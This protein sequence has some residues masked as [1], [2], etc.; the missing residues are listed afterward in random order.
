[1]PTIELERYAMINFLYLMM[2]DI[3][4]DF[5][6]PGRANMEK[7]IGTIITHIDEWKSPSKKIKKSKTQIF[8]GPWGNPTIVRNRKR[9]LQSQVLVTIVARLAK[10]VD[11]FTSKS[12]TAP[13][14]LGVGGRQLLD[15]D[16]L[17]SLKQP[18]DFLEDE[19]SNKVED[20]ISNKVEDK[21]SNKVEDK[22]S[23]KVE[24]EIS[25]KVE[26][27][28][29]N[30]VED[31]ISNKVE[32]EIS[33]KVE[34][35]ISDNVGMIN[36]VET[37]KNELIINA[38]EALEILNDGERS[39]EKAIETILEPTTLNFELKKKVQI[40]QEETLNEIK[41]QIN[42]TE[43]F[44]TVLEGL[45]L[46]KMAEYLN[47]LD[48]NKVGNLC[49]VVIF[50]ELLKQ[51]E[52]I[53]DYFFKNILYLLGYINGTEPKDIIHAFNILLTVDNNDFIYTAKIVYE[54]FVSSTE[55]N[56]KNILTSNI[57]Y[58]TV[59]ITFYLKYYHKDKYKDLI[60]TLNDPNINANFASILNFK[61]DADADADADADDEHNEHADL[62]KFLKEIAE[63]FNDCDT[64]NRSETIFD[65]GEKSARKY[66]RRSTRRPYVGG[67]NIKTKTKNKTKTK[68]KTKT[69][70]KTKNKTKRSTSKNKSLKNVTNR[71]V[72]LTGL[73]FL[74][75][76]KNAFGE[77]Y[78][79]VL[80]NQ[81]N[82]SEE[83][84]KSL[85]E[86]H[87]ENVL[88]MNTYV[89][90]RH[91]KE[92][93]DEK[94]LQLYT[95]ALSNFNT[96]IWKSTEGVSKESFNNNNLQKWL[97]PPLPSISSPTGPNICG[98]TGSNEQ[99][100]LI[101]NA[102][103]LGSKNPKE[104]TT[105]SLLPKLLNAKFCPISGLADPGTSGLGGC[106]ADGKGE[107]L[108]LGKTNIKIWINNPVNMDNPGNELSVIFRT[109]CT[110]TGGSPGS[111]NNIQLGY[112]LGFPG[113]VDIGLA[114]DQPNAKLKALLSAGST[115]EQTCID[116]LSQLDGDNVKFKSSSEADK[117]W[118]NQQT[119]A[120]GSSITAQILRKSQGDMIQEFNGILKYGGYEY[121]EE[122][123]P[124]I[125]PDIVPKYPGGSLSNTICKFGARASHQ[126]PDAI[127]PPRCVVSTDRPSG[128][129]IIFYRL[130]FPQ[131][132]IN[133]HSFGG[134][135]TPKGFLII[136]K[137]I[138]NYSRPSIFKTIGSHTVDRYIN[139]N[140][141]GG[142]K[143]E[144]CH[145]E[146]LPNNNIKI[147][148]GRRRY[149]TKN[150]HLDPNAK[151]LIHKISNSLERKHQCIAVA[152]SEDERLK[153]L[154]KLTKKNKK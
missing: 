78:M 147:I 107:N 93:M 52:I 40:K 123:F 98:E 4:H 137:D 18:L 75:G 11:W 46:T 53:K 71:I 91:L 42:V 65:N 33:N 153:S 145:I 12:Q 27:E 129:R 133:Q 87:H 142:S 128:A 120:I 64:C 26:D 72:K 35:E 109:Y 2:H 61:D 144:S 31:E 121:A 131:E 113:M 56:P 146:E 111:K 105:P 114:I 100:Y 23:N 24:D 41:S 82:R 73:T 50:S 97:G 74:R 116:I 5:L 112:N 117:W 38:E 15:N 140:P 143:L 6:N 59:I 134:Y 29:S 25:N 68:T 118:N 66:T 126:D 69:K 79:N 136:T 138:I 77:N 127:D 119:T 30:K 150:F 54:Y 104:T 154:R 80:V 67:V 36:I 108:E 81:S 7:E 106:S 9:T 47:K 39:Y 37:I 19:I 44:I 96:D 49:N 149:K 101:S 1:M 102:V 43:E 55:K 122:P 89:L 94:L 45:N 148:I 84:C 141:N 22:I 8:T 48:L 92:N 88:D 130:L 76:I 95:D 34:D 110:W 132:H 32:D 51:N 16:K 60:D 3:R 63:Y 28:I 151:T 124:I 17:Y 86:K 57:F 152:K 103:Q 20:K 62:F 125:Y 99:K 83:A 10:T 85:I 139:P 58:T 13:F 115:L 21:I 135:I 70:N 14:T 90:D